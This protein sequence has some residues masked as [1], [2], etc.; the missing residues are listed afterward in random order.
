MSLL[1][2]ATRREP[3]DNQTIIVEKSD[4]EQ[5]AC[6]IQRWGRH[7]VDLLSNAGKANIE[8]VLDK[9]LGHVSENP[10]GVTKSAVMLR[11][12]LSSRDMKEIIETLEG[13]GLVEVRRKGKITRFYPIT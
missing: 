12:R 7:T 10:D 3:K 2:S 1:I 5:A 13:R 11:W 8:K 4:I 6:Y 9:V